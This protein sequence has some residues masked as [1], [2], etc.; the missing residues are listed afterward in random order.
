MGK[1]RTKGKNVQPDESPDVLDP[2]C[3]HIRKGLEQS[4]LRKVQQNVDWNTCQDCRTSASEMREK[5]EEE[6][7]DRPSIWLCLKC[8]HRGCGRNSQEQHALKH[9]ETPRSEPHCLVLSLDNWSVWCYL[10][11]NEV[12]YNSSNQL[13]QLVDYVKKQVHVNIQNTAPKDEEEKP[14]ENKK[15]KDHRNE[16]EREKKEIQN[17]DDKLHL[18]GSTEVTVKGL[19]NLGNTCFFNAV[20]QNLS[21]TP[22]LR[23]LLKEVKMPDSTVT[24]ETPEFS[25]TEPLVVTLDQPRPLTLAMCQFLT[26]MQE[27]KKATVTPKELFS[28]V[29]KKA[30]RFKGYQQQDSQELLRYLLD[31]M[32][33]EEIQRKCAGIFKTLN[34]PTDKEN[35]ELKKRIKEYEKRKMTHSFVDRIFGGELTSTIMCDECQTV[36]LVHESFLDLSLPVLNEQDGK[37][38]TND[39]NIKKI[40]EK[41]MEDDDNMEN[42]SYLKERDEA[43]GTSKHLQKKAKKVAKRQAKNQR[44]QQ[45]FQEKVIH[46]TDTSTTEKTDLNC[47]NETVESISEVTGLKQEELNQ[48]EEHCMDQKDNLDGQVMTTEVQNPEKHYENTESSDQ[49]ANNEATM[50]GFNQEDANSET[51][52]EG[53]VPTIECINKFDHLSLKEVSVEEDEDMTSDFKLPFDAEPDD[54]EVD[55]L[56]ELYNSEAKIYEV[57]NEDPE[58]AFCTLAN[59]EA[60]N[61]EEGS[62]IHCLYQFTRNEKLCENNKLLCDVCTRRQLCGPKTAEKNAKKRV[63]TNAKKQMLVSLAPPILTL[64]LKRFQQAGYN[65]QKVNKHIKFPEIMDLAPF[66]SVKCKNVAEGSSKV[67]YSLYG[68]VE[69]SGTMRSGHYT[70][71]VKTRATNNQLSDLVLHGK[72][73]QTSETESSKGQWF[74]ISDTHVQAVPVSRVLNSQAYLL[75]YERLL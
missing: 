31:G 7:E 29:C 68:V 42:D 26:E 30:I 71:Y 67:L 34:N 32:R 12:L 53:L 63:Y 25:V 23:E 56:N 20:L 13:G 44:R 5:S 75:F 38:K 19:S 60:L 18:N 46:L 64:H 57:V 37:K 58:T 45:K 70:A 51:T 54:D 28:Q 17:K 3:K 27:T 1:K 62:I 11:D 43:P 72:I 69:H 50:N 61:A 49:E 47:S 9:Y 4:H 66:C 6:A 15:I 73:Q 74:H 14:L 2:V 59:R 52:P 55:N 65:L 24:I 10:C 39:K 40:Q 48:C 36:S 33:T 21:Q 35:E 22:V 41:E 16:E 8:G